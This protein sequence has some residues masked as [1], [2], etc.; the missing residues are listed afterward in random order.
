[1][2]GRITGQQW[3]GRPNHG[4]GVWQHVPM[5]WILCICAISFNVA[6]NWRPHQSSHWGHTNP[7]KWSGLWLICNRIYYG[8]LLW[9][10]PRMLQVITDD[11]NYNCG[12]YGWN[13]QEFIFNLGT[14][15]T[16]CASTSWVSGG[17]KDVSFSFRSGETQKASSNKTS[18]WLLSARG[19]WRTDG[20]LWRLQA[21]VSPELPTGFQMP[22]FTVATNWDGF[23]PMHACRLDLHW[24]VMSFYSSIIET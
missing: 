9:E 13:F 24:T 21:V 19:W 7:I 14:T 23:V 16:I 4:P 12:S 15:I 3:C 6:V 11:I 17:W 10:Q 18:L 8:V 5:H 2:L 1:M 22:F 20:I